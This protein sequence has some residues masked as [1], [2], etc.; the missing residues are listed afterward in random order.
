MAVNAKA[1][2]VF[3]SLGLAFLAGIG[4]MIGNIAPTIVTAYVDNPMFSVGNA[5][6][7][8]SINMFGNALGALII[9]FLLQKINWSRTA[10]F[11]LLVLVVSDL[12]SIPIN[13]PISLFFLRFVHGL[14]AGALMGI[15]YAAIAQTSSP[16]RIQALSYTM[17]LLFGGILIQL[18]T[19]RIESLGT[20]AVSYTH[21]TL[22][23]KA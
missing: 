18:I 15:T 5:G 16:E 2:F 11:F 9:S 22:P 19:P 17:Q 3:S 13:Q 23:T 8:I 20:V 1:N 14:S 6:S 7:V 21:L 12:I 10:F 4:L